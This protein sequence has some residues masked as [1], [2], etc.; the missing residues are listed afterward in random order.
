MVQPHWKSSAVLQN[1][2]MELPGHPAI[3]LLGMYPREMKSCPPK[4]LYIN[5]CSNIIHN[6]Q[7][8]KCKC[9]SIYE[10]L[11]KIVYSY[12]GILFSNKKKL[13]TDTCY[14]MDEPQKCYAKE[15]EAS[16]KRLRIM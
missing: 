6:S 16:H 2:N 14:N 8:E 3:P 13:S 12:K 4:K 7:K 1:V 5:V 9:P 15:K 10:W 11:N